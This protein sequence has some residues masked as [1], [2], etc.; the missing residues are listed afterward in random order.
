MFG[1]VTCMLLAAPALIGLAAD[2]QASSK[3]TAPSP[4]NSRIEYRLDTRIYP[5]GV[6][7]E[8]GYARSL[9]QE[10]D[11]LG[12]RATSA[13]EPLARVD[14]LLALGNLR[15][16]RQTEAAATRWLLGDRGPAI[17]R[18]ILEPALEARK[19]LEQATQSIARI[20]KDAPPRRP[21]D[22]VLSE[23]KQIAG[24]LSAMADALIALGQ[25][26]HHAD[27]IT[28]LQPVGRAG[29][30]ATAA[31]ANLWS[32]ALQCDSG[33]ADRALRG[34][35]PATNKPATLPYDFFRSFLYC[36]M[37]TERRSYSLASTQAIQMDA[38]LDK[39]FEPTDRPAA[40][41]AVALLRA[42]IADRWAGQLQ[43][44]QMLAYAEQRRAAATRAR[45][46]LTDGQDTSVYRLGLS[47]PILIEAPI[48][49]TLPTPR[50]PTTTAKA[51]A[52]PAGATTNATSRLAQRPALPLS[53]PTSSGAS[54]PSTTS[55][56]RPAR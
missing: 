12:Q 38:L 25:G 28:R 37:L 41:R 13:S 9:R 42:D 36:Q 16:A 10:A 50:R 34:T 32:V 27:A 21:S 35:P 22:K 52:P 23:R 20:E 49:P 40:R 18:Q 31:A 51:L 4:A 29:Q 56:S 39:W 24:Y 11:R 33:G 19:V 46:E 5:K 1:I 2:P 44:G 54:Q 55:Q 45:K 30:P 26:S 8:E 47:V 48:P 43:A 17:R 7:D 14:T 53:K 6:R 15:L 3:A